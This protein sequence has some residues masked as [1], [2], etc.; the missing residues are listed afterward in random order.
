MINQ[1]NNDNYNIILDFIINHYINYKINK[2]II[3]EL[4]HILNDTILIKY[5]D[6]NIKKLWSLYPYKYQINKINKILNL[7]IHIEL[8]KNTDNKKI[9]NEQYY[10]NYYE[11]FIKRLFVIFTNN[12]LKYQQLI[13][14]EY[15]FII[16]LQN[17]QNNY[18]V[19]KYLKIIDDLNKS[20]KMK[21]E[22]AIPNNFNILI[23][24]YSW[25]INKIDGNIKIPNSSLLYPYLN[26]YN[27]NYHILN[28]KQK[29]I[30]WFGHYG[31]I[32]IE[33]LNINIK[34]LPVQ[35]I[36]LEL[37]D[38]DNIKIPVNN[39]LNLTC[40]I[41]YN[42]NFKKQIINSLIIGNLLLIKNEYIILNT[43]PTFETNYIELFHKNY[44]IQN[45][46]LDIN[47][48]IY[49]YSE[50]EIICSN[51]SNILNNNPLH[52][53]ILYHLLK[54]KIK[55]FI[56]TNKLF[57]MAINYLI[58]KDYIKINNDIYEKLMYT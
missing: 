22:L 57:D 6:N 13:E 43:E 18:N 16:Y 46:I 39:I 12:N 50:K 36:I 28:I 24:S 19:S 14:Y 52:K 26:L 30:I 34:L 40:N 17:Y 3:N 15:K 48:N 33:Y 47:L 10:E 23:T 53:T 32:D 44:N 56:V 1:I 45:S 54:T 38:N 27:I 11:S 7:Y 37:F 58:E 25:N 42:I 31:Y 9:T 35:F 55:Q 5:I 21:T 41:N 29:I 51:I 4:L 49:V 20:Y 8:L 2:Y